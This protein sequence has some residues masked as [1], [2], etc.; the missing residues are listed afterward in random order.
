MF[1]QYEV[2]EDLF[3]ELT[4]RERE[5]LSYILAGYTSPEIAKIIGLSARTVEVHRKKV[6][7]K[8]HLG[9]LIQLAH[10]W[11]HRRQA[12]PPDASEAPKIPRFKTYDFGPS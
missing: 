1:K 10:E 3:P 11:H 5:V 12:G 9:H 7:N 2:R 8:L 6:M 4:P